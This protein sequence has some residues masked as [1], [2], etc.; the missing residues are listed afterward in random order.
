L[1]TLLLLFLSYSAPSIAFNKRFVHRNLKVQQN[2][3]MWPFSSG[4]TAKPTISFTDV[5]PSWEELDLLLRSRESPL[6]R[7]DFESERT[8]RGPTNHRANIRLFDAPD[9]F[10]PEIV[11]YRDQ[12]AWCPYCEKVW[13]QLE[14]KRIPYR[15]EKAPLR[16][17]GEKSREFLEVSPRGMLPVAS[18][19][20]RLIS[21]SNDIIF[22]VEEE[23]PEF[24]PLLPVKGSIQERRMESLFQLER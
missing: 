8:G 11:L 20:G 4:Q 24:T 13:L 16:C 5:S 19:R 1:L 6:E 2:F 7:S 14:E 9:V 15:V 23:F 12:A 21:E 18:V 3:K 22:A 10:Q 17:Y